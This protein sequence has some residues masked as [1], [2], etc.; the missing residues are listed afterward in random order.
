MLLRTDGG[1]RNTWLHHKLSKAAFRPD[2]SGPS[3]NCGVVLMSVSLGIAGVLAQ[4]C[5]GETGCTNI[6]Q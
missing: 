6:C 2:F 4:G 5:D 3:N 1:H